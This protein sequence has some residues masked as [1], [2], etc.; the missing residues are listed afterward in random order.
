MD[1]NAGKGVQHRCRLQPMSKT[2]QKVTANFWVGKLKR[3]ET[4]VRGKQ[5]GWGDICVL[6]RQ[7]DHNEIRCYQLLYTLCHMFVLPVSP[8]KWVRQSSL[9]LLLNMIK[10]TNR[11]QRQTHKPR[12][13]PVADDLET[14]RK[15]K[16]KGCKG[17]VKEQSRLL[18]PKG[19]TLKTMFRS[20]L[21]SV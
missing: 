19:N 5:A 20:Y 13:N 4:H 18:S 3:A 17:R 15:R 12:S 9:G 7:C 14:K 10:F 11:C 2:R 8:R 16:K 21:V 1:C 6:C